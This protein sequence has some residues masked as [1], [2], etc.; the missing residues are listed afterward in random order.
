[1]Y[2]EAKCKH[3]INFIYSIDPTLSATLKGASVFDLT[4]STVTPFASSIRVRP[5]VKSTSKTH[6]WELVSRDFKVHCRM[7]Y[8]FSD[9]SAN[10]SP[11]GKRELALLQNLRSSLLI[12]VLHRHNDL[13]V[14]RV[15][16]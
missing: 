3:I 7:T 6:C 13:G 8:Q 9:D 5:F 16:D 11:A 2:K 12:R 14:L 10:T 1:M 4:S 15:A